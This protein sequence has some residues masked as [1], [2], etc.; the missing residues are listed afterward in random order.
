MTIAVSIIMPTFNRP[1]HVARAV[2]SVKAQ[3]FPDWEL[4]ILDAS[5]GASAESIQSLSD[6]DERV[7][8]V[9]RSPQ[10]PPDEARNWGFKISSGEYVSFLDSDDYWTPNRLESHLNT[11]KRLK[12]HG[13]KI[14]FSWDL[15]QD[16]GTDNVDTRYHDRKQPFTPGYYE[17]PTVAQSLWYGNFI[18]SSSLFIPRRRIEAVGL[19]KF[20]I[21]YDWELA[22][23][24][25][26]FYPVFL[27]N[28][29]LCYK[30]IGAPER[31]GVFSRHEVDRASR[32]FQ[33]YLLKTYP[34]FFFSPYIK[35]QMWSRLPLGRFWRKLLLNSRAGRNFE[36]RS[37]T[38]VKIVRSQVRDLS[39]GR[40]D[41]AE[42]STSTVLPT[43][44]H[45]SSVLRVRHDYQKGS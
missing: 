45:N 18:H 31:L 21:L 35:I 32:Q 4:I 12:E 41:A 1:E 27:I 2:N 5:P 30:D 39:S 29:T 38:S 11:W 15:W 16:V 43:V 44:E 42:V 8:Y 7:L 19:P 20:G 3:T 17:P 24:L 36:T 34:R 23:K 10:T 22:V 14:G 40:L 28:Q 6:D 25:S 9:P 13:L 33:S 26:M 37:S